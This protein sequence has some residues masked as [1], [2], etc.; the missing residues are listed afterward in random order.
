MA[1][2][3]FGLGKRPAAV[4]FREASHSRDV[5][6]WVGDEQLACGAGDDRRGGDGHRGRGVRARGRG[7]GERGRAC[8]GGCGGEREGGREG[9]G[10]SRGE[11]GGEGEG[12]GVLLA[13]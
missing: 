12:D 13:R 11:R 5:G 9:G 4:R 3:F 1:V 2:Q 8:E 6:R 7:E 10:G